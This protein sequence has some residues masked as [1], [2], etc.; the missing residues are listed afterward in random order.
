ML[1]NISNEIICGDAP[2]FIILAFS[3]TVLGVILA[4]FIQLGQIATYKFSG[5]C[6]SFFSVGRY[7]LLFFCVV[8]LIFVLSVVKILLDI[9]SIDWLV[10]V[11]VLSSSGFFLGGGIMV[12]HIGQEIKR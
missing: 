9:N 10:M 6:L 12:Y 4:L 11:L 1:L 3:G 7:F 2:P 5:I 8:L